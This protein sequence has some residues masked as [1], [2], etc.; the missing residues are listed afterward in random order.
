VINIPDLK[1]N[2]FILTTCTNTHTCT[3]TQAQSFYSHYA[4]Q[5]SRYIMYGASLD[6]YGLQ[7][8]VSPVYRILNLAIDDDDT[9][10]RCTYRWNVFLQPL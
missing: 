2:Q 9:P 8:E 7:P 4:G 3:H 5:P 1:S 10:R 6:Y